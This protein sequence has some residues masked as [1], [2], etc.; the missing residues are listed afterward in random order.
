MKKLSLFSLAILSIFTISCSSDD[1]PTTSGDLIGKW[2]FKEYKVAGQTIPYDDHEECGKDYIQFN[3]NG[4]GANVD[5]WDCVEDIALFNYTRSGNN[6]TVTSDGESDTVQI[7][8]LSST[9]LKIK[10]ISDF[11]DDGD[12]ETVLIIFTRN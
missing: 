12:N 2:Y 8:E 7:T 5:V 9:T 1:S 4:T 3:A 6:I 10:T 11:D